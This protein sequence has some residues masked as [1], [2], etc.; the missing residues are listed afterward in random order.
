MKLTFKTLIISALLI[1]PA[2]AVPNY[3]FIFID[4]IGWGD[5][6]CYGSTVKDKNGNPITPNLDALA[7][8]GTR[9]TQG[10]VVSPICSPSRVGVLTGSMPARHAINSFLDN[11][12]ANQNRGLNDWLQ[13]DVVTSARI[14]RDH[15]WTTGQFGKWH[16]GGGRDVNN[17]PY[18]Q[19]YGF[20]KSLVAFEGMGDRVLYRNYGLSDANADVPGEI[21]WAEWEEGADLHTDAAIEFITDAVSE[22]KPFY[23]HVPYNDT[24][25][26]FN[27]D[28]G[29]E[30]DFDH[31]S[32][33]TQT[34]LFLSE[35]NELDKEIGRLINTVDSLGIA[36]E[37]LIVVVGDNGPPMDNSATSIV[38]RAGGLRGGKRDIYEGGVR[39]P[40]I[41]RM[42]GTVPAQVNTTT[43]VSTLDLLPTYCALANVDIPPTTLD[44]ENMLDVF[45]GS[46]RVR[47][48]DLFWEFASNPGITKGRSPQLAI[49]RGDMKFLRDTN[50]NN[51]EFYDLSNDAAES[52]HLV[53]DASQAGLIDEMETALMRWYQEVYLGEVGEV[54]ELSDGATAGLLLADSYDLPSGNS[55]TGGFAA[56]QGVNE[57]LEER[58][59]GSMAAG[60]S[61]IHTNNAKPALAHSIVDNALEIASAANA[62][63]FQFSADGSTPLDFGKELAGNQYEWRLVHELNDTDPAS[64][65]T[66][67]SI[68]D[69][70]DPAGGVGGVDLGIQLD[71]VAGNTISVFKRIDAASHTGTGDINAAIA[72]GLP[73][74]EP[75][76]IRVVIDDSNDYSVYQTGYQI[77]INDALV[78][79][80]EIAFANDS[81]YFI[82]DTAPNT[83]PARY[84]D[85][86]LQLNEVRV[87]PTTRVPV[88]KLSQ[89]TPTA[90]TGEAERIRLYWTTQPG[91]VVRPEIS[92]NL[93]D[94]VP[95][96][97]GE[98]PVEVATEF[99]TIRWYE[100]Q[101]PEGYEKGG[102]IRLQ[103]VP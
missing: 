24:H 38:N 21:T 53:N 30:N 102:F 86:A 27:T 94:W 68:S 70:A 66:T 59:S 72:T 17:A 15:G 81:R 2:S 5:L 78:D 8:S 55:T 10:Y 49:R 37:T 89:V 47:K 63:A 69:S 6:S 42:P 43:A 48:R 12:A 28:P 51:R 9:F 16:M 57:G 85:F 14:F 23:V 11:K 73:A 13:P 99:G 100:L 97:E 29:K 33:D 91:Q 22:G 35:L 84:D 90:I 92:A 103:V 44:G 56:G 80:G 52:N 83:G 82:F 67:L 4:D 98:E 39:E 58:L 18:P 3:L 93:S 32:S 95:L 96:T 74:G 50:G 65:R 75:V 79:S 40:F 87:V 101:V 77:Y 62:T 31:I 26:P 7:A 41:I 64:A 1:L 61:Y 45:K 34:K 46:T 60:L 76:D 19:D 25:T 20:Q 54:V 71:L 88:V 36:E